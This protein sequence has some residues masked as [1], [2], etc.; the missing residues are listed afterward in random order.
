MN[1]VCGK[2]LMEIETEMDFFDGEV[3]V[4]NVK[5]FYCPECKEELFDSSTGDDLFEK[6]SKTHSKEMFT[7]R[8]KITQLGNSL[9]IPLSKEISDFM[10]AEKGTN[11]EV[12]VKNQKRLIVDF[13]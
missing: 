13:A 10:Q 4:R 1:C 5:A 7:S 11:I 12:K 8:K 2:K 6:V 9:S 3:V